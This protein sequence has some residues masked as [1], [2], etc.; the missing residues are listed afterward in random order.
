MAQ[1]IQSLWPLDIK[2][3]VMSPSTIL[4]GQAEALALQTG[5]VLLA[6]VVEE[7][8]E[9]GDTELFLD[10]VAPALHGSRHRI[11]KVIHHD[12]MPYPAWVQAEVFQKLAGSMRRA[13][14]DEEFTAD[15][16]EVLRSPHVL[17]VAQSLVARANE[18]LAKNGSAK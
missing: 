1:N 7:Q 6:E 5:G 3:T 2:A 8:S 15:V 11:L 16:A 10:L 9:E 17:S 13:D 18:A 4:R 14:T 12:G